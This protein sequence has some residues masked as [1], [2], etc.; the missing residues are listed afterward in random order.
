VCIS[1][2]LSK[3]LDSVNRDDLWMTLMNTSC[4]SDFVNIIRSFH[5]GMRACVIMAGKISELF[6]VI[7]GTNQGRMCLGFT[8]DQY[9]FRH[10]AVGHLTD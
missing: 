2:E 4:P 6:D 10:D 5:D 7:N 9:I 3:A 1:V 8:P